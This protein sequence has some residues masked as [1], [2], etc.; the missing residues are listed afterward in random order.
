MVVET[1][2]ERMGFEVGFAGEVERVRRVVQTV[3]EA[4][5]RSRTPS[6]L[7]YH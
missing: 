6:V 5:I 2:Q 7:K 3:V 4:V 1:L